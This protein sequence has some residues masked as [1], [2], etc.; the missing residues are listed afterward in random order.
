MIWNNI[1]KLTG[2]DRKNTGKKLEQVATAF[3]TYFV[4]SVKTLANASPPT[5]VLHTTPVDET[6]PVFSM[7][8]VSEPQV[9]RI[10][11][12]VKSSLAKDV[13][14]LDSSFLKHH[15]ESLVSP[16]TKMVNTSIRDAM[17][18]QAWKSA[19]ITPM[20]KAG[21]A[22]EVSILPVVSK[23]TE[24]CIAE[25]LITH[26]NNTPFSLHPMQFGFRAKHSTETPNCF[27]L[28]STK[29]KMDKCGVV[30]AV[31]LDL[32]KAFDTISHDLLT[33]K[34]S[35]FNFNSPDTDVCRRHSGFYVHANNKTQAA[36]KLKAIMARTV[37][38]LSEN[39]LHLNAKKTVRMFSEKRSSVT[40]DPDVFAAKERL[41]VVK[42][43]KYLG[44]TL[45]S[46]LT[47]KKQTPTPCAVVPCP[48][49]VTGG[50]VSLLLAGQRDSESHSCR[51]VAP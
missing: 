32:R 13:F 19:I 25:Q 17:F 33:T 22:T 5:D 26:L 4:E 15:R 40:P 9:L 27:F 51:P 45:D 30:G 11:G 38:W 49:A 21:D 23:I 16:I 35:R 36:H 48:P 24:K 39:C 1:K 43:F 20:F 29:T 6:Q 2:K 31:F 8:E 42:D 12:A 18:P 34:H 14:G 37:K 44:I 47:F 7:K 3:N 10:L 28:E 46:N 41:E 50:K